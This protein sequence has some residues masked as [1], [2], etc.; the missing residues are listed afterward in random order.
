MQR[1]TSATVLI[2]VATGFGLSSSIACRAQSG[3][4]QT[5]TTE[6]PAAIPPIMYWEEYNPKSTLVVPENVVTSARYP[7]V[8]VHAHQFRAATLSGQQVDDLL[9][10]MDGLNMATMVNL[11][12]GT[13]D[14]LRG[15]IDNMTGR[16][17]GR[18]LHFA[19]IT[20]DGIDEPGWGARTAD[21]LEEDVRTGAV[22]LK[23]YKSLGMTAVDGSGKRIA[24]D[25]PR[26]APVWD[27]AG[28]LGI[29]VLIHS[30]DPAPFWQPQDADNE[31]WFELKERPRRIRPKGE[32][33]P[34]EQI[35]E[36]QH[37]LFARH[38]GTTFINAHLGW[39]GNNLDAL[40][41]LLDDHSNVY[42]ETGA[43]LA[44]LGRQPKRA[45][46]FLTKYKDRI[47]F[48]KDAW[49]VDEYHVYFRTFETVD[50]YFDY[51]RKRHAFWKLYGLG[52]DDD[53]LRHIYYKNALRIVPGLDRSL[54]PDD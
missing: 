28:E 36:E 43:V 44:E 20:F 4:G 16:Y 38:A 29:P 32:F 2:F 46:E 7:F 8:D 53:V 19:N 49:G 17:P 24:V 9:A 1:F 47:L 5:A 15:A 25:D 37:N 10:A 34:W 21:Q 12:G 31:R 18:F 50:E 23:I 26:I 22:G 40:G 3:S 41:K 6:R 54:F 52:L 14:N 35:I 13:G 51:Y 45:K 33:P 39:L 42:S 27:R 48:G 11:S 30:A